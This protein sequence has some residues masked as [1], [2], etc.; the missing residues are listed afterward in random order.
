MPTALA[1]ARVV[2]TGA[3]SGIGAALAPML[4]ERGATVGVVARRADRLAE[5]LARCTPHAPESAMW[6]HDLGDV[7]GSVALFEQIWD[8]WGPIDVIV[9]NAAI[10]KRRHVAELTV[11][12]LDAVMRVNFTTPIRTTMALL[13]RFLERDHG[14]FVFVSSFGGRAGI[15]RESAYCA[16]KFAMCGWAEAMAGD[17][18]DT[19]V[20]V[21]L[22][23]PG[24]IDTEIW[25]VPGED[26]AHYDGPKAP[27][28]EV[29]AGICDAIE[30]EAFELYVP[31]MKAIA[32]FKTSSVQDYLAATV[33]MTRG[34][35]PT[36]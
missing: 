21:R 22:V 31:D 15:P 34:G 2:V 7:E 30:G 35:A 18:W 12:E 13:P 1:G 25:D 26:A 24:A 32:E 6:A 14:C 36:P 10:P 17:L 19:G 9:H 20:D 28:A 5:V 11:E 29:A 8:D 16:S 33:E 3:S 27:P 23:I 4:A